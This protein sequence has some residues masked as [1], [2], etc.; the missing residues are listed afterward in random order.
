MAVRPE[1]AHYEDA[2]AHLEIRLQP[3]A[4]E[5]AADT[6]ADRD[7]A[8]AFGSNALAIV[9]Q[10]EV[11]RRQHLALA[12]EHLQSEPIHTFFGDPSEKLDSA[13]AYKRNGE[14]FAR[15]REK[16]GDVFG[17]MAEIR[18]QMRHLDTLI[19][20]SEHTIDPIVLQ[21]E[22]AASTFHQQQQQQHRAN[23]SAASTGSN[24]TSALRN[25][26]LASRRAQGGSGASSTPAK[27]PGML[28]PAYA[29][30]PSHALRPQPDPYTTPAKRS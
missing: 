16:L 2:A 12:M 1:A 11:I 28:S 8:T 5:S 24:A 17:R 4:A 26:A 21:T 15:K 9:D 14:K 7:L 27:D 22:A 23:R 25:P 20:T 6:E 29:P 13:D 3:P 30:P 10:F 18:D 19:S